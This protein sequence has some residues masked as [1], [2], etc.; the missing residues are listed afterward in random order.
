MISHFKADGRKNIQYL[1]EQL[2]ILLAPPE[3][4]REA[5]KYTPEAP[6]LIKHT[7]ADMTQKECLCELYDFLEDKLSELSETLSDFYTTFQEHNHD[8]E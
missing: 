8:D 1:G 3:E 7:D 5:L 4:V 6:D 2:E